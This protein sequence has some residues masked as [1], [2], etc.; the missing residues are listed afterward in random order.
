MFATYE[1]AHNALLRQGF[2][3]SGQ[4]YYDPKG[5]QSARQIVP[6]GRGYWKVG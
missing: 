6:D 4:V 1:A 5:I 3:C 2:R